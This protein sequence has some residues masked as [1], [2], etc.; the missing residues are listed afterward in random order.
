MNSKEQVLKIRETYGSTGLSMYKLADQYGV[1]QNAIK[2]ILNGVNWKKLTKG[3]RVQ[4]PI[5]S[6]AGGTEGIWE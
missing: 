2:L 4:S 5:K 6:R 1:S 3:N